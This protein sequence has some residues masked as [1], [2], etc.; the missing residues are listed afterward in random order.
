MK[1]TNK[2]R[3]ADG[4]PLGLLIDKMLK[5]YGLDKKMNEIDV[6]NG[7]GEM[8]GIAVANRTVDLKISNKILIITLDS[9][10]IREELANGKQIII[11]R[12]NQFAEKEIITDVWFK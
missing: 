5:A 4:Q 2:Y 6:L 10:V 11:E 7:W 3:K 1:K 12:E 8:M 9:S